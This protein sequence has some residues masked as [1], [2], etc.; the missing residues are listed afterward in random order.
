MKS[1]SILPFILI[2]VSTFA[3]SVLL[4][5]LDYE[6]KTWADVF[7]KGNM[8]NAFIFY[9][10]PAIITTSIIYFWLAKPANR[11]LSALLAMTMG[12]PFA[13]V[14]IILILSITSVIMRS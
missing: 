1:K 8:I 6:T 7:N 4:I 11:W 10:L 2:I 9:Y 5:W 14:S 12:I 3:A 13:F